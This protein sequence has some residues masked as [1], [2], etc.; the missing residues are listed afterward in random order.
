M[1]K[2]F[3]R[4]GHSDE[5]EVPFESRITEARLEQ[6]FGAFM[7]SDRAEGDDP[8]AGETSEYIPS[9]VEP[10]E[11]LWAHEKELYREKEEK[12]GR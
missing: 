2:W 11:E 1:V 3:R 6:R 9:T 12:E 8:A 5:A 10:S 7:S 4:K